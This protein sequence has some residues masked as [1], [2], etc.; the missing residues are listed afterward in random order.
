LAGDVHNEKN[1]LQ[2]RWQNPHIRSSRDLEFPVMAF[3]EQWRVNKVFLD[4]WPAAISF[5]TPK[6]LLSAVC[7]KAANMADVCIAHLEHSTQK[8]G[9]GDD[10][11]RTTYDLR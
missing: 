3:V 1:C 7:R 11:Q 6:E 4:P 2:P 5:Q 10:S 9:H 8:N